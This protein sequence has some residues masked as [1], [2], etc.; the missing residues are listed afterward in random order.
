VARAGFP[1]D[2]TG[3]TGGRAVAKLHRRLQAWLCSAVGFQGS[4]EAFGVRGFV[5]VA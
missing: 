2:S 3:F 4:P 1:P 5:D